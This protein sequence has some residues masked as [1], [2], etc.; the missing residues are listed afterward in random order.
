MK[1]KLLII[2]IISS[3]M[4]SIAPYAT[5]N[6][7]LDVPRDNAENR[8]TVRRSIDP[9]KPMVAVTFDDGP[10]LPTT[11][12]LDVL[13]QHG[14]V[15]T[16][17]IVG[18]MAAG[19]KDIVLRAFEMGNEIA[20]HTW[21]HEYLTRIT[22]DEIRDQL[23]RTSNIIETIT[24]QPPS[25]MR[26]PYGDINSIGAGI[27][28][29]LGLPII[30]WSLDPSDWLVKDADIVYQRIMENVEDGDI[31]LLHDIHEATAEATE[32]IIPSLI[33][34]G[35]QLVTVS[36]LLYYA[37]ITPT[38]G[39]IYKSATEES[40]IRTETHEPAIDRVTT[41]I[42]QSRQATTKMQ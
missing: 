17:Y 24:G 22:V 9:T 19:R 39:R 13:E 41:I 40:Q 1:K 38:P 21:T 6:Q 14:A 18:S 20:N 23:Q 12:I 2:L 35:F 34:R 28:A 25:N 32:R 42:K 8:Q 29:E 4:L 16:F 15:A 30:M 5:A 27:A 26:P 10:F 33:E 37:D 11:Q 3:M 7:P 36:E 31:I